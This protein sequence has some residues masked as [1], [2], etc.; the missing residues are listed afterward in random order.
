M[1]VTTATVGVSFRKERSDSSAS[2]TMKSPLPSRAP[3]PRTP[4]RPPTTTV[5]S[6]PPR[7]STSATIEVVVV[8][9]WLPAMATPY[10]RRISSASISAR[11][12]TGMPRRRASSTSG[13][14]RRTA[15]EVT[16]TCASPH[17][18][19]GVA[20]G[21]A[22]AERGEAVG[23]RRALEVG[24]GDRVAEVQQHLGDAAHAGAADADEVHV[25]DTA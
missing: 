14:S 21:D 22:R 1:F 24:A 18:L 17:V 5:G 4:S 9:P 3:E 10:L 8:L 16:T 13:L 25:L 23:H 11:G 7:S 12:M 20:V 15:V 19:G 6:R 2:A